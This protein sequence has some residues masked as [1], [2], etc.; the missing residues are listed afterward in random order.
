MQ[1]AKTS[2]C[3]ETRYIIYWIVGIMTVYLIIFTAMAVTNWEYSK[4]LPVMMIQECIPLDN[5]L[6]ER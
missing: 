3:I 5:D 2:C 1:I 6:G 4:Y